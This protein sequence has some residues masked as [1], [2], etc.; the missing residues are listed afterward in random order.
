M[1]PIPSS[2]ASPAPSRPRDS[3]LT[4]AKRSLGFGGSSFPGTGDSSLEI[5]R[6]AVWDESALRAIRASFLVAE[7]RAH[8]WVYRSHFLLALLTEVAGDPAVVADDLDIRAI[9]RQLEKELPPSGGRRQ[10]PVASPELL[11]LFAGLATT[12]KDLAVSPIGSKDLLGVL[13]QRD[14]IL[15]EAVAA[16]G[17]NRGRMLQAI[18]YAQPADG[19]APVI[20]EP[21]GVDLAI[22]IHNDDRTTQEFV[23]A[24]LHQVVGMD[25]GTAH[26]ETMAIHLLGSRVVFTGERETALRMA[27]T[28]RSAAVEAGY[29][30]RISLESAAGT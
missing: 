12:F 9:L 2:S 4:R 13:L 21:P 27:N 23:T 5:E 24:A 11:R 22:R 14:H 18:G 28:I 6:L 1:K 25:A 26:K 7:S 15:S 10:P 30:L 29:P 17:I 20:I 3:L 16:A 8:Q 19:H